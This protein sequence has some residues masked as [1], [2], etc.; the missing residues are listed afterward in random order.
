MPSRMGLWY[1]GNSFGGAV[2]SLLSFGIGQIHSSLKPWK[3][4]YIIFGSATA[5][6]GF[7]V[8]TFLPDTILSAKFLTPEEKKCAEERVRLAG[9]GITMSIKNKWKGE[10]AIEC[11]LDP[12]TWFC[13]FISLLT[14]V[15]QWTCN[16]LKMTNRASDPEWRNN[17]FRKHPNNKLRIYRSPINSHLPSI[18]SDIFSHH[19]DI[20]SSRI[21]L[22][23]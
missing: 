14:M 1:A 16:S 7:L 20:R 5:I 3:L 11:L 6:W 15:S 8:L 21:P 2:A 12:K 23:Q 22:S 9:T 13:F 17:Q 19:P 4:L 18:L 10:Q